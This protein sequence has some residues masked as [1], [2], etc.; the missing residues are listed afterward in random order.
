VVGIPATP[1]RLAAAAAAMAVQAQLRA[2]FPANAGAAV[3]LSDDRQGAVSPD[4]PL[5]VPAPGG[6]P[7]M[8]FTGE[9]LGARSALPALLE[10]AVASGAPACALVEPLPRDGAPEWLHWL[11][12][13]VLRGG[14]DVVCPAY[15]RRKLENLLNTGLAYPL[16]RALFGRRL[17]QP[18][19]REIALSRRLAERILEAPD[20][21]PEG[22]GGED[23]WVITQALSRECRV[24]ESFLGPRPPPR[25]PVPEV[26]QALASLLGTIFHELELHAPLWQRT[27][28]S[29]PVET[30]GDPG[31]LE[32]AAGRPDVAPLVSA[33]A[34]GWQD[35]RSLWAAVLPPQALL[36]LQRLPRDPPEAFRMGDRLWA[37]IV[38]DFAV[39][40]RVKAMDRA[41]LLRSMAPLY[42]GWAAGWVNEVAALDAAASEARAER[43]CEAF[44]AEKPYLI[45]RWRWP[46]RF[47]P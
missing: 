23:L 16:T 34:L 21:G 28:S 4:E 11:L 24:C 20:G 31:M 26:P 9:R 2:G 25:G 47:L 46:D 42:L 29:G 12:D 6:A 32:D 44:E 8:V 39:G 38:Y 19:G 30:F 27:R 5:H 17:R 36:A 10:V 15:R 45:S 37:R 18:L 35:L 3:V 7:P 33:F 13:P 22:E 1:D 40:W 43:L 41:Q 14:F